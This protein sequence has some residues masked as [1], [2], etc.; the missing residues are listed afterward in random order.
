[1]NTTWSPGCTRAAQ[2]GDQ[3][4]DVGRGHALPAQPGHDL[5]GI[6]RQFGAMQEHHRVGAIQRRRQRVG[7]RAQAH[8]IAARLHRHHDAGVA[9]LRA[10]AGQRGRDRGRVVGEVVVDGDALRLRRSLPCGA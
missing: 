10:Q 9:D 1:M 6:P 8:R 5:A 7:M 2:R 3:R 4:I